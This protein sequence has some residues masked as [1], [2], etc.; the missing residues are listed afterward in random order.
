M[1][2]IAL[3]T[4]AGALGQTANQT[5]FTLPPLPFAYD[6]LEPHISAQTLQFHH[7]KHHATYVN[8][9]NAAVANYPELHKKTVEELISNPAALPEAVR[10][11][12]RNNGGGHANHTFYWNCLAKT[13]G[14][15]SA[16][17]MRAIE[18]RFA[19]LDGFKEQMSKAAL[20]VFGSGWAWLCLDPDKKLVIEGSPNQ[21]T[22]LASGHVPLLTVDVW[23]HAY[24]LQYQNRRADYVTA[25]YNVVNWDF[26]SERYAKF[27]A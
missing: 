26:V 20:G 12:I 16:E 6:A 7:D 24:Y 19:S 27:R 17:L 8:N 3:A 2:N 5:P 25:L 23:E 18:T 10:T 4:A 21:E 13:G 14:K 22:P 1:Q 15:P 9:L 11:A